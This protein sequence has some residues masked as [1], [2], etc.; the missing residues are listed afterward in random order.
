MA[1]FFEKTAI[2]E[3]Q[4]SQSVTPSGP[5]RNVQANIDAQESGGGFAGAIQDLL[6]VAKQGLDLRKDINEDERRRME[7][8]FSLKAD[9]DVSDYGS[10]GRSFISDRA[11]KDGRAIEDYSDEEIEALSPELKSAYIDSKGLRDK[12]YFDIID[13]RLTERSHVLVSKQKSEIKQMNKQ[14]SLE[15]LYSNASN[16]FQAMDSE[17]YVSYLKDTLDTS[18]GPDAEIQESREVIK[19]SLIT[20]LMTAAMETKDPELLKKLESKEMKEFFN[21]PDYDNVINGVRQQVQSTINKRKSL[22]F[23]AVEEQGFTLVDSGFFK[24]EEDVDN[25]IDNQ[26]F[27]EGYA[28]SS[29]DMFRLKASLKKEVGTEINYQEFSDAVKSG[30]FTFTD[31]KGLKKEEREALENKLFKVE[32]G[33]HDTSPQ[34]IE[35]AINSGINDEAIKQYSM[36]G[37]PF[38]SDIADYLNKAP[39]GGVASVKSKYIAYS[40]LTSLTQDAVNPI[41]SIIKPKS[42]GTMMFSGN[43]IGKLEDGV[44][45]EKEFQ[46]A[47]TVFTNDLNK[48]ID[49]FGT[50]TSVNANIFGKTEEVQGWADDTSKDVP[51]TWDDNTS[52]AYSKRQLMSNFNIMIDAGLDPEQAMSK[53]ED[54]FEGSHMRFENADGSEGVMPSEFKNVIPDSLAEVAANLPQLQPMKK[55]DELFGSSFLFKGKISVRPAR[56][57]EQTKQIEVY[58]DGKP[59]GNTFMNRATFDENWNKI[60][61]KEAKQ[62]RK[63]YEK[64]IKQEAENRS[65]LYERQFK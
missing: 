20:P 52:S 30:D 39:T 28:P 46:D 22:N 10:F 60:N 1:E 8:N 18:V 23:D 45:D 24:T 33:I 32:T 13:S 9:S 61:T 62:I 27:R 2:P 26:Q 40:K 43:L 34:G 41:S 53:A 44:I 14:K 51:W 65:K 19:S 7:K 57:Y 49:S 25:F 54:M 55:M 47:Y 64:R 15:S 37:L 38:P 63:D 48:N 4:R 36:N 6:G 29:K 12:E 58:Y 59:V 17:T 21:I 31:R 16:N 11:A 42:H 3:A 5:T 50:Y 35:Q 56:N